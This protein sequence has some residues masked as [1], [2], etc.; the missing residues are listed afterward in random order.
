MLYDR[1][2]SLSAIVELKVNELK[3]PNEYLN[4]LLEY[5]DEAD[6]KPYHYMVSPNIGVLLVYYLGKEKIADLDVISMFDEHFPMQK[7]SKNFDLLKPEGERSRPVVIGVY[8][9]V[10]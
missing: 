3:K 7:V 6:D 8:N 4:Q 9:G 1:K 10:E 2:T 5:L